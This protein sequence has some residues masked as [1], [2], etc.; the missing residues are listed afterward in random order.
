MKKIS[1]IFFSFFNPDVHRTIPAKSVT[2]TEAAEMIKSEIYKNPTFLV[3]EGKA[4]KTKVLASVTF[5]VLVSRRCKAGI[6]EWTGFLVFDI[7]ELDFASTM[8]WRISIDVFLKPVLLF[9]S[10]RGKGLKIVIRVKDGKPEEHERYF[11]AVALYLKS[12]FGIDID[13]SGKDQTRLCFICWDPA[14]YFN[15]EGWV[16]ADALLR[17]V[18]GESGSSSGSGSGREAINKKVHAKDTEKAAGAVAAAGEAME[19]RATVKDCPYNSTGIPKFSDPTTTAD[20]PSDR[21]NRLDAV[22]RRS[23]KDLVDLDGWTLHADG[24]HLTREGKE[25]GN[26]AIFNY[27]PEYGFPVFTNYSTS[28]KSFGVKGWTPV[29]IICR[30]EFD[31]QWNRTIEALINEYL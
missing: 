24:I 11:K 13:E 2:I 7:D 6:L 17:L 31:N 22:Y 29:Q 12:V 21:L 4:L 10:P 1:E 9:I 5:A 19:E 26:S 27:Y 16:E 3:R 14:V 20:R 28:A 8:K 15:P 25:K 23:L 18:P 30:L